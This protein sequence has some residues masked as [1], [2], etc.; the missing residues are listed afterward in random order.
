MVVNEEF[1]ND[2]ID[3]LKQVNAK[4]DKITVPKDQKL[5]GTAQAIELLGISKSKF[6]QLLNCNAF[7]FIRNGRKIQFDREELLNEYRLRGLND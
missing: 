2:I 3:Q 4:V 7:T 1:L 6:F 5:I